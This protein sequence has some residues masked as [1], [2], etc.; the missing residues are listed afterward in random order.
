MKYKNYKVE[1]IKDLRSMLHNSVTKWADNPAFLEKRDGK[2]QPISFARF[3]SD[4]KAL[5]TELCARGFADSRIVVTGQNCYDWATV[6][7]TV[8]NGLGVIVPLDKEIP[9]E[10]MTNII[11][12]SRSRCV[13]YSPKL[14]EKINFDIPDVTFFSFDD[15]PA[16]I[17][18]GKKRIAE[19]DNTYSELP[20]DVDK[21]ASLIFTSGTTGVSKGVMLSQK[22]I[23]SNIIE[24]TQMIKIGPEDTFLSILPLHHCYECTCGFLCQIYRGS[25]IAYC[26]GLH[27]ILK[28]MMEV[29]PTI[30]L[31][32]PLLLET[33]YNKILQKIRKQGMEKKVNA[34]LKLSNSLLK[35]GIDIRPK[36]FAEIQQTFGGRLKLFISGG[37]AID[38]EILKG[39]RGFGINAVQGYGLTE[40]SP[41]AAVNRDVYFDDTSA[42]LQTP[43]GLLKIVDVKDDGT[44]EICYKGDNVM[45]G[46][47]EAPDLTKEV[48]YGGYLHTGDL[49]YI[50]NRGFLHITGRKK[51]VIVTSNGKNIFP[52]E[53]ETYLARSKYVKECV[54]VG[55]KEKDS[56]DYTVFGMIYPDS[57]V[58]EDEFGKDYSHDTVKEKIEDAVS[59]A[60]SMV[61]NYKHIKDY[62]I[63]EE[64][65]QK[66][67]SNKIRRVGLEDLALKLIKKENRANYV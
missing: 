62:V 1:P 40:C 47:Y 57:E 45:L 32:V 8:I 46:Y 54:V 9:P 42:G 38:P 48:I 60:N 66:N 34:A 4:T 36:L 65:F 44:G 59:F 24:M 16:L 17:E 53:L 18:S 7:M 63:T 27:R 64:E 35:I 13:F 52:E 41:L 21:L 25:V 23:F 56:L 3:E 5:G 22:N 67:T 58:F 61:Q 55:I 33:M 37:A 12:I 30:V 10:E 15:I 49:G 51:N 14:M 28:N 2:Y 20:I 26:E 11:E 6:Y 31:C 43:N 39:L 19:G 50:D 29:K